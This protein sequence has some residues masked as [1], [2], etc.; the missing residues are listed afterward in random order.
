MKL[1][2][3]KALAQQSKCVE[4]YKQSMGTPA[5]RLEHVRLEAANLQVAL[6]DRANRMFQHA[7]GRRAAR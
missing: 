1:R 5:E 3:E 7:P 2:L 6:C 4:S